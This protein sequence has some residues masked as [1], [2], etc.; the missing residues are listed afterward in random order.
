MQRSRSQRS[1][2]TLFVQETISESHK[3]RLSR[4]MLRSI[5]SLGG[6]IMTQHSCV[7]FLVYISNKG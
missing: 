4:H 7:F 1:G 3:L 6:P 5:S 2:D